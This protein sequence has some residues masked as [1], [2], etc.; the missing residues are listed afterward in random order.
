MT[1]PLII[2]DCD[3]VLL[4]MVVPFRDWLDECKDIEFKLNSSDF[5]KALTHKKDQSLI[6]SEAIWALLGEFFDSEMHRQRPINGA[7]ETVNL[8]SESADIV[9]LTNLMDDRM[10]ARTQQLDQFGLNVR[11]FC[12]QGPKGPALSKIIDQYKPSL[13]L[14]IDDIANHHQ[15]VSE[16]LPDIWR[17]HMVGEPLLAPHI[18]QSEHAHNRIDDWGAAKPWIDK[19][20][21]EG[22]VAPIKS[23]DL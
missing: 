19:I 1:R 20:L 17:L 23:V 18:K 7:I 13:A 21:N 12:N 14:F 2:S 10:E 11:V 9:V 22:K 4:H 8:L 15:S 3:E 16:I 6:T 5:S